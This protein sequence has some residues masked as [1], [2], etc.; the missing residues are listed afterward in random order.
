MFR[1]AVLLTTALVCAAGCAGC[2]RTSPEW[3]AHV[4]PCCGQ[5]LILLGIDPPEDRCADIVV[6]QATARR[7]MMDIGASTSHWHVRFIPGGPACIWEEWP[8]LDEDAGLY[9]DPP[10]DVQQEQLRAA[11]GDTGSAAPLEPG[12]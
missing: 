4:N 5:D 3:A 12:Q 11:R 7:L 2:A 1:A 9:V 8:R 10:D 6:D